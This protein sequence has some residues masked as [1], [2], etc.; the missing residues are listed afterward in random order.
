[1]TTPT[2]PPERVEEL[3]RLHAELVRD[4]N[5]MLEKARQLARLIEF[6]E[7]SREAA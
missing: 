5:R 6:N 1:M 7:Q 2:L 4:A 3:K